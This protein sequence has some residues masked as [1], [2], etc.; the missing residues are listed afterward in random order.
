MHDEK[1]LLD[2]LEAKLQVIRD[3][4]QGVA[5]G[6]AAGMYVWGGGGTSKSFTVEEALKK[7][8]KPYKLTNSRVTAKGLFELLRDHADVVHILDDVE[9]L[10]KD[11]T[12]EGV[13]RAAL[14]GQVNKEG[15]Q[16]RVVGWSIAGRREEVVF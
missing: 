16:E 2:S 6:F 15:V 13:L 11:K 14:W 5:E 7:L 3:R 8:G 1:E 12:A 9:T 4:V 10:L